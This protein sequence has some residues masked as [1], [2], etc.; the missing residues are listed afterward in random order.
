[1][2]SL[3]NRRKVDF[4]S[5]KWKDTLTLFMKVFFS[6]TRK[7]LCLLVPMQ[8]QFMRA[9]CFIVCVFFLPN[10]LALSELL[11]QHLIMDGSWFKL[12][13]ST[14]TKQRHMRFNLK[15]C[16]FDM[17]EHIL[18]NNDFEVIPS[19]IGWDGINRFVKDL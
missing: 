17:D 9:F 2:K 11:A 15:V 13:S 5:K 16:V 3:D 14:Q 19:A 18:W 4:L 6:P 8:M 1:M 7:P 10:F 12:W